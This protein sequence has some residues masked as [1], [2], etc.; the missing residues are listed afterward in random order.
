VNSERYCALLAD[1]LKP[2]TRTKH[3]G[4]SS[5]TVILQQDNARPNTPDKTFETNR[6]L[7]F[8]ILEHPPYSLD[9][10]PSDFYMLGPLKFA[11]TGAH[12]SNDEEVTNATHSWLRGPHK[13]F[14]FQ[15]H[16]EIG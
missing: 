8:E 10:L 4:R 15:W 2:A 3:K 13:T 6:D 1:K 14:F 11:I 16:H 7:K 12:A 9:L 5:Q